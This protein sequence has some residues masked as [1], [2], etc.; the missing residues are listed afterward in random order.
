MTDLAITD[1]PTR[2]Q[3]AAQDRSLPGKV[4]GR[5][6][7]ALDAMV[8]QGLKRAEAAQAAGLTDHSLYTALRRPHVKGYYLSECEVLRLSGRARRIHRLEQMV[9]QDDNKQA[10]IN[11]ARALDYQSDEQVT[12]GGQLAQPGFIIQVINNGPAHMPHIRAI[13]DKPL[14][15]HE[16]VRDPTVIRE[17]GRDE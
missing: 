2:Q 3:L 17:G 14:I 4:T 7:R 10:V 13:E 1:Q 9:E 5:L 16:T 11:A 15:S 8:W 6:K 12:R